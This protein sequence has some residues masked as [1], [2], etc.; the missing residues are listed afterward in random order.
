MILVR[1]WMRYGIPNQQGQHY[2]E[3]QKV[4]AH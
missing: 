3:Q 2:S 1:S 4:I